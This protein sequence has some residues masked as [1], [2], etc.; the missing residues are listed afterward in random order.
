[1][2]RGILKLK[3]FCERS[4]CQN[5]NGLTFCKAADQISPHNP[6]PIQYLSSYRGNYLKKKRI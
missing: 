3:E 2:I 1:M 4:Y 6:I 5:K